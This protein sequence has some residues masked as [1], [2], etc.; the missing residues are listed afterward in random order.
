MPIHVS[1]DNFHPQKHS[2]NDF[3]LEVKRKVLIVLLV[4]VIIEEMMIHSLVAFLPIWA[5][6]HNWQIISGKV[7]N[8]SISDIG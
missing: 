8:I 2:I 3:P 5:E 6:A 4:I 1:I 7:I